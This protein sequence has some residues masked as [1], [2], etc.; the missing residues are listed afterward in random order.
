MSPEPES[1]DLNGYEYRLRPEKVLTDLDPELQNVV[2]LERAGRTLPYYLRERLKTG[3]EVVDVIAKLRHPNS[4]VDGLIISQRIGPIVT[5]VVK[6]ADIVKVRTQD[7]VI[8]LKGARRL[9]PTL[10]NSVPEIR[11][12]KHQIRQTLTMTPAMIDG[13]GVIVGLV[14]LGC[15]FVHPNFRMP[16]GETR[17]RYL[18]DQRGGTHRE[19]EEG[20]GRS[21]AGFGYGREFSAA[22]L[23]K[24]LEEEDPDDREAPLRAINYELETSHGTSVMDVAAGNGAGGNPPGVAPGADIIFVHSSLGQ[25]PA[26]DGSIANS[27][28][29]L[30]AVKYIFDRAK[31]LSD[32]PAV[33]NISMNSDGGPHDGTTPVELGF[34]QLLQTPGRA[35]VIAAGNRRNI[36]THVKRVVHPNQTRTLVW[37]VNSGDTTDNKLEVWYSGNERLEVTLR[38]P[39]QAFTHPPLGPV[40]PNSTYTIL[41][42]EMEVGRI[43]NRLNDSGNHDNHIAIILEAGAEQGVWEVGLRSTNE[44]ATPFVIHAWIERDDNDRSVFDDAEFGDQAYTV[45]TIACGTSTIAVSGYNALTPTLI[46]DSFAEGPTR[47]GKQ[48]PDVSAPGHEIFA[49][50]SGTDTV[51][52]PL[53]GTSL[54]AQHVSGTVALLLQAATRLLTAEEIKTF[55]VNAARNNPPNDAETWNSRYGAGRLDAAASLANCVRTV[56]PVVVVE[57]VHEVVIHELITPPPG[58]NSVA[59]HEFAAVTVSE[60]ALLNFTPAVA[61]TGNGTVVIDHEE[62]DTASPETSGHST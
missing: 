19:A 34:E 25:E 16:N 56:Q 52:G 2:L 32:M 27:R 12:S 28:H 54:A 31:Q 10:A 40:P 6:A 61:P 29:L 11:A 48:K 51:D 57:E 53:E 24:A 43:F 36:G 23:N 59:I 42:K 3:E 62:T 8:S 44:F 37:K 33:V 50:Q 39:T 4:R 1:L 47:D 38:P 14:D 9:R 7:E 60:S 22:A 13:S 21:P 15:D 17:I 26:A 58:S 20:F 49:A 45:G 5:G 55:I 18:W 35:I 30:E 46:L 41:R